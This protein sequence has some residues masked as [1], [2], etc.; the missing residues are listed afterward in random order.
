MINVQI[1]RILVSSH[2][3]TDTIKRYIIVSS[4][5]FEVKELLYVCFFID[6]KYLEYDQQIVMLLTKKCL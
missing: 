1:L 2:S 3:M 4:N 5:T 6:L